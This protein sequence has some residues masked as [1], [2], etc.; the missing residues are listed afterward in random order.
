MF[1]NYSAIYY[2]YIG[3]WLTK[4]INS[5]E[6]IFNQHEHITVFVVYKN[7]FRQIRTRISCIH[8]HVLYLI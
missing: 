1:R 7:A 2:L 6:N 8:N 5:N 4:V 3:Q